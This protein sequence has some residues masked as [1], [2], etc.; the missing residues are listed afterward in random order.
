MQKK[1]INNGKDCIELCIGD[2]IEVLR[3]NQNDGWVV[4]R[5]LLNMMELMES[6]NDKADFDS[7]F[8]LEFER[9]EW[10]GVILSLFDVTKETPN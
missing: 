9:P 4:E 6:Q 8:Q 10:S 7:L 5:K 1:F 2:S 3:K